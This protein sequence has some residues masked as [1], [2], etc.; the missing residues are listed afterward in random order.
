MNKV[1]LSSEGKG[2]LQ[3]KAGKHLFRF[4]AEL[5][6]NAQSWQM[7]L[8]LPL[9]GERMMSLTWDHLG[10]TKIKGSFYAQVIN[11]LNKE[12]NSKEQKL[13][14][15]RFLSFLAYVA[16]LKKELIQNPAMKITCSG[17][18]CVASGESFIWYQSGSQKLIKQKINDRFDLVLKGIS[19]VSGY[20]QKL[21]F[22]VENTRESFSGPNPLELHLFL[23]SCDSIK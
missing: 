21:S 5:D 1:C 3:S 9:H 23:A 20:F 8:Q 18:S 14:L 13:L 12:K 19:D 22:I 15:R 7:A 17:N 6:S 10:V 11:A 4:E 16:K 2:R